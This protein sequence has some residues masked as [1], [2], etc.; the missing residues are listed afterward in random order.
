MVSRRAS[1]PV[2]GTEVLSPFVFTGKTGAC[3]SDTFAGLICVL[4]GVTLPLV[5]AGAKGCGQQGRGGPW[6]STLA[7]LTQCTRRAVPHAFPHA[8]PHP[9]SSPP[10]VFC[11][12]SNTSP[13]RRLSCAL[14]WGD[15]RTGW[16]RPWAALGS[17]QGD[18]L[19]PPLPAPHADTQNPGWE[20]ADRD[21]TTG[22]CPSEA[23]TVTHFSVCAQVPPSNSW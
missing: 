2:R 17:P 13:Q 9:L 1:P 15:C 21:Y 5:S 4:S 7:L 22:L 3:C 10:A 18:P 8:F 12:L 16:N 6:S 14:C 20:C 11:P 23:W 19:Q